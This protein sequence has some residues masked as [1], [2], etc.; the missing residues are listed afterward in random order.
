[1]CSPRTSSSILNSSDI[2][3]YNFSLDASLVTKINIVVWLANFRQRPL[4]HQSALRRHQVERHYL[5]HRSEHY[6]QPLEVIS[7]S[8]SFALPA[9]PYDVG[10]STPTNEPR[11][12]LGLA[13]GGTYPRSSSIY[14]LASNAA[15]CAA[16]LSL[17]DVCRAGTGFRRAARSMLM[18]LNAYPS[19]RAF[20]P[21]EGLLR[22][23]AGGTKDLSPA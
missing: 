4:R 3:N 12:I 15:V 16:E 8:F 6:F 13:P 21:G 2:S 22:A 20:D 7:A 14:Q 11:T 19:G 10:A 17:A 23:S 9:R 5:V 1:M 18:P